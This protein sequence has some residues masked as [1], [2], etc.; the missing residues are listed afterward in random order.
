MNNFK[1]KDTFKTVF[2]SKLKET[3]Q[4]GVEDASSYQL[5]F[6]LGQ[7]TNEIIKENYDKTIYKVNNGLKRCVYFSM[8][9]LI[10]RLLTSNLMNLGIYNVVSDSFKDYN[11]S[12]NEIEECESDAGLGNGGLGRLAACFL[13]SGA[14]LRYPL[15][16]NSLRY[17]YGFFSQAIVNNKQVELKDYW[18]DKPYVFEERNENEALQIPFYGYVEQTKLVNPIYV[19]AIPY[20]IYVA[21]YNN[22]ITTRLRCWSV[23][24][25]ELYL[26]QDEKY[27][28]MVE[29]I[30]ECLYPDDSTDNGK[31]LR[32]QQEY[33][34]VSAGIK[35]VIREHKG[36]GRNVKTLPAYYVFQINDTHPALIIPELLRILMDEEG[37]GYEEAWKI[38]NSLCAFTNHT[39]LQEALEKWDKN[40][41]KNLLPRIFEILLEINKRFMADLIRRGLSEE[42][43]YKMSLIGINHV[44][45]ANLCLVGAFSVNGVASLHTDILKKYELKEFY[46]IYPHKFN[47][48]TNGVTHRRWLVYANRG[49]SQLITS[50]IGDSWITN[51]SDIKNIE[52]YINDKAFLDELYE[53][54][55]S[56]KKVLAKKIFDDLGI[57]VDSNSIFDIQ[58]KRIHEYKR[59]LM[60]I[61]SVIHVYLKLRNDKDFY[62]NYY[63]HTFIF[64]GKAAPSYQMAKSI[65]ELINDASNFINKDQSTNSKLKVVFIRNY[66]VSYAEYLMPA[67]DVSEQI[68]TASKE[69]SGTGNMKF[70]MNGAITLGTLDGANVE[71]VNSAGTDNEVIFGM[72]SDEVNYLNH[73]YSYDS[74]SLYD[75]DPRIQ[76]IFL[77]IRNLN[78]N[79][80]YYDFII[81]NLLNSDSYY[82]LKDFSSYIDAANRI[83]ELYKDKYTWLKMSLKNISSSHIFTSDRTI[84]EYNKDIWKLTKIK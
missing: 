37:L 31:T 23:E 66:N 2:E 43:K 25:S 40:L 41:F 47:N 56:N 24:P 26:H 13:D 19:K 33:L 12:L 15:Y 30:C 76:E 81:N 62:N 18:L 72:S 7:M 71:I 38:T 16:G 50:K 20:D 28:K 1:N 60:N 63:P 46:N 51:F 84:E 83:N 35:N 39:I 21:G 67:A 55:L 78:R 54:K 53:T 49:L 34:F 75:S 57:I 32:I 14:S 68:S 10:G 52:E 9:F 70:M 64:G 79:P 77:F 22:S 4:L 27:Y 44:R 48:K 8:E 69:A 29:N 11:K 80:Y 36:L 59:Q 6:I 5:F 73:S 45:M 17:K 74:K 58:V 42:Q 65:I 82:I 61:L 3:F